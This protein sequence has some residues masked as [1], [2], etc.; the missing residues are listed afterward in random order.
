MA[1]YFGNPERVKSSFD[2]LATDLAEAKSAC[3]E[4]AGRF[5]INADRTPV[6]KH[7]AELLE[8]ILPSI[9]LMLEAVVAV[10]KKIYQSHPGLRYDHLFFPPAAEKARLQRLSENGW[11]PFTVDKFRKMGDNSFLSWIDVSGLKKD[12]SQEHSECDKTQ[13]RLYQVDASTYRTKH[14]SPNC[15]CGFICPSMEAIQDALSQDMIPCIKTIDD[16]T[17]RLVV[18]PLSVS[19]QETFVAFSHV[20]ADG[21]GSTSEQGLP[22]CQIRRLSNMV[23]K[24]PFCTGKP[25]F[26]I[27][28]LCV[29]YQHDFRKK[30]IMLMAKTY[31]LASGVIVL[32]CHVQNFSPTPCIE[33]LLLTICGSGWME[34]LW[35]YQEA[36]LARKLAFMTKDGLVELDPT[37]MRLPPASLPL[38]TIWMY[39]VQQLEKLTK[40]PRARGQ[41]IGVVHSTLRWRNTSKDDDETL[42]IAGM[43]DVDVSDLLVL[44]GEERKAKFWKLLGMVPK[45]IIYLAGPKLSIDGFGWAPRTLMYH[46][47]GASTM[48]SDGEAICTDRGLVGQWKALVLRENLVTKPGVDIYLEDEENSEWIYHLIGL[49]GGGEEF[50]FDAVLIPRDNW[51][52]GPATIAAAVRAEP[53]GAGADASE[54]T[55]ALTQRMALRSVST[56][57]SSAEQVIIGGLQD[58]LLC[59]R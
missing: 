44:K 55:V 21:L 8:I 18:T 27:D 1:Y 34:R 4:L 10:T 32:D 46:L 26:W 41:M 29:P 24:T 14:V 31:S 13:C 20:W 58:L 30:A 35:T 23:S 36:A 6:Y 52:G 50:V 42:A 56:E 3:F 28:S 37:P 19:T 43:L 12:T 11:C 5:A 25:T 54:M 16:A 47:D 39:L 17:L 53:Q 22:K 45:S 15:E 57:L 2:A 9:I 51:G 33:E 7:F 59:I 48:N 49:G 38:P 40:R